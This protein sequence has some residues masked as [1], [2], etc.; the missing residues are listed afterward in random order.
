MFFRL[1]NLTEFLCAD[2]GM[3]TLARSPEF[4]MNRFFTAARCIRYLNI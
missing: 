3:G 1:F 2:R 4:D